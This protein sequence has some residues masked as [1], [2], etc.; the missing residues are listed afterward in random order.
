MAQ[1][2]NAIAQNIITIIL[3]GGRG[4]RLMNLT[5]NQAKPAVPFGGGFRIIDFALSNCY[6]S[7]F[8]RIMMLTQYQAEGLGSYLA[9]AWQPVLKSEDEFLDVLPATPNKTYEGTADAVYKNIEALEKHEGDYVLILAGDHVYKMD[10]AAMLDEHIS[11]KAD[12]TIPCIEVPRME[13]TG[14]GVMHINDKNRIIDFL[15]KPA[16]PPGMPSKPEMALASMGIYIFNKKLL[17]DTLKEDAKD[18]ASEHDF[19]TNVIPHLVK[20]AKVMA[21]LFSNSCVRSVD[22][23]EAYWRDVGT[24]DQY[25]AAHMDMTDKNSIFDMDDEKWPIRRHNQQGPNKAA[26]KNKDITDSI[27]APDS[28]VGDAK[29]SK[30]LVFNNVKIGPQTKISE[31][32]LLPGVTLGKNVL[33]NKVIVAGDCHIPDGLVIGQDAEA[34]ASRFQR[35][36]TGITL[37]TAARLRALK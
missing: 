15:E 7:G 18:Q 11:T 34:D 9:Q 13:A 29:I 8:R 16:D 33:L 3:A 12:V 6:N 20:N 10:Y 32:V 23:S 24:I 19:G 27:I 2:R 37:V 21:H 5:E 17:I 22:G 1:L 25:W 36:D 28:V 35:T 30:S 4:S 26:N 31:S 14:F